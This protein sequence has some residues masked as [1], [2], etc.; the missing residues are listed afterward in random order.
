MRVGSGCH[1]ITWLPAYQPC[2]PMPCAAVYHAVYRPATIEA[3]AANPKKAI[4]SGVLWGVCVCVCVC[5]VCLT[6]IGGDRCGAGFYAYTGIHEGMYV[7]H[8]T[9]LG[10]G[11]L[12]GVIENEKGTQ[13]T[14]KSAWTPCAFRSCWYW[15]WYW[16][17][18]SPPSC[19]YDAICA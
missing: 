9:R 7:Q 17:P 3:A 11:G 14:E 1:V 18:P 15:Y 6:T 16:Y 8:R 13:R 19:S 5:C 2:P 10:V 12:D 4:L